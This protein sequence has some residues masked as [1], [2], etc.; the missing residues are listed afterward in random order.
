MTPRELDALQKE[1][2]RRAAE[3][4]READRLYAE[5]A[6]IRAETLRRLE[7]RAAAKEPPGGV[8]NPPRRDEPRVRGFVFQQAVPALGIQV[9]DTLAYQDGA[10]GSQ[11]AVL[12]REV[13]VEFA[14][15]LEA[16]GSPLGTV[17]PK[18]GARP[19]LE[20]VR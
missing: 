12:M 10:A 6:Q 8:S 11:V 16:L 13:P 2:R 5:A 20:V 7:G 18:P 14:R 15:A 9:G 19:R 1:A 3:D 17:P 4:L